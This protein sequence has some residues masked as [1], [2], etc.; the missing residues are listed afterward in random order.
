MF[1]ILS[2]CKDMKFKIV[3]NGIKCYGKRKLE[4]KTNRGN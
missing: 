1:I 2:L 4:I 3:I